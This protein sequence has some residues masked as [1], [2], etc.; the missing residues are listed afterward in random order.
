MINM[1]AG[2]IPSEGDKGESVLCVSPI[3]GGSLATIGILCLINLYLH[4]DMVFSLF[5][6]LCLNF[7]RFMRIPFI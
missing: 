2:L 5:V 3:S 1:L 4:T 7:T 6:C